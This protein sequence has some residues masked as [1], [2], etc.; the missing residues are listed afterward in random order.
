MRH[1][2]IGSPVH[3]SAD[4]GAAGASADVGAA[5]ASNPPFGARHW[6]KNTRGAVYV[7]FLIA[8]LPT[9]FLYFGVCE[10]SLMYLSKL[11]VT[12]ATTTAVRAAVVVL[13]DHP[14][15]YKGEKINEYKGVRKELI[16]AAAHIPLLATQTPWRVKVELTSEP[17]TVGPDSKITV[18]VH[19]WHR[20]LMPIVRHIACSPPGG[21]VAGLFGKFTS[22]A[23]G[24]FADG[25]Y[26]ELIDSA[27]MSN[28]GAVYSY[29]ELQKKP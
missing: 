18:R 2:A 9:F 10:T 7:E 29:D 28:H 16:E 27:T 11:Q 17:A 23:L 15:Y 19:Y 13:P 25:Y 5:G 3:S 4:V 1:E 14:K 21:L 26:A 6:V 20:C 12:R 24:K 22:A 8:F